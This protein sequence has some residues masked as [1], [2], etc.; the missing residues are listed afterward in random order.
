MRQEV[1]ADRL[2]RAARKWAVPLVTKR[3]PPHRPHLTAQVDDRNDARTLS[4]TAKA[5]DEDAELTGAVCP[6]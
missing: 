4:V 1:V 5:A 3:H 2:T 6:R